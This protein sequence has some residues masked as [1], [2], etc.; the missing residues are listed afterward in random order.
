LK[1]QR[2]HFIPNGR[3]YVNNPWLL[4]VFYTGKTILNSQLEKAGTNLSLSSSYLLFSV[5]LLLLCPTACLFALL[6]SSC[7]SLSSY[8]LLLPVSL[9]FLFLTA[10]LAPLL[11]SFCPSLSSYLLF[12]VSFLFLSP[13]VLLFPL[14]IPYCLSLPSFYRLSLSS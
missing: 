14:L 13:S 1:Q 2:S 7:L 12:S 11:I 9:L 4:R 8:C 10:C 5:S 3:T 6:I